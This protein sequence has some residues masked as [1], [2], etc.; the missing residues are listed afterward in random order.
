MSV[1]LSARFLTKKITENSQEVYRLI[2]SDMKPDMVR[3]TPEASSQN[4]PSE[5]CE[6]EG[7]KSHG[8]EDLPCFEPHLKSDHRTCQSNQN[9][10]CFFF[11]SSFI[12]KKMKILGN[13][14]NQEVRKVE[15]DCLTSFEKKGNAFFQF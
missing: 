10:V 3:L 11:I 4:W 1:T 14:G 8:Q 7:R 9:I 15:K 5:I 6:D 13:C 2:D 12:R